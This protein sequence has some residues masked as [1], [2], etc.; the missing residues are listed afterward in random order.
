M[1]DLSTAS[2][3]SG[4]PRLGQTPGMSGKMST[5]TKGLY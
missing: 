1:G 3:A 4:N 2:T 5:F